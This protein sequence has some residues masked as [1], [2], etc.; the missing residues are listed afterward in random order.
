MEASESAIIRQNATKTYLCV[1]RD[2][3]ASGIRQLKKEGLIAKSS[4]ARHR[5]SE[6]LAMLIDDCNH[7][8]EPEAQSC[9]DAAVTIALR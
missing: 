4:E 9:R 2:D 8:T 6:T 3:L 5:L 7:R 1:Y